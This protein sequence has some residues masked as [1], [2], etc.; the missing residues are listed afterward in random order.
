MRAH[1]LVEGAVAR[2]L[3]LDFASDELHDIAGG[4]ALR[5]GGR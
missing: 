2:V 1:L 3:L 5:I 4:V